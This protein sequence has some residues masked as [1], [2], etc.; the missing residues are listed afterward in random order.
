[1]KGAIIMKN[2]SDEKIRKALGSEPL[3]E[4]LSPDNIKKML[5]EKAPAKKRN[6]ITHTV[7]RITAAAAACAIICGF[8]VYFTE[9]RNSYYTDKT[10]GKNS[11]VSESSEAAVGTVTAQP[12]YMSGASDYNEIYRMLES[13]AENAADIYD[14][15]IFDDMADGA[16]PETAP[17]PGGAMTPTFTIGDIEENFN[18]TESS[19]GNESGYSE[20]YNQE[21]GVLEGD[22]AL[23]DGHYIYYMPAWTDKNERLYLN[24]A[25]AD[26]GKFV[27]GSRVEIMLPEDAYIYS[28]INMFLYNE[29]IIISGCTYTYSEAQTEMYFCGF[30]NSS[31]CSFVS[32]YTTGSE[33]ELIGN[34][35]QE[36]SFSDVRIAPDGYLY[37]I[38]NYISNDF[39]NIENAEDYSAYIPAYSSNDCVKLIPPENILLPGSYSSDSSHMQYTVIGSLDL[40][41]KRKF[42]EV[43]NKA[44]A[45]YTGG[46]YCSQD[47][48]YTVCGYSYS[49]ITRIALD[50]GMITPAASGKVDG[51]I[52][53]Q[54]SMSEYNGYFRVAAT[55]E[56]WEDS[57]YSMDGES[58]AVVSHSLSHIDNRVYV[59]DLD[60]NIIGSIDGLGID[61]TIKS[62]SFSGN[63]AYIVTY[64]Q[65]DP[66]YSI[67]LSNPARPVLMDEYKILGYSTYMQQWSDGL[68]LGF[69]KNAD[70]NGIEDGIKLVMFDNS[71]PYNLDEKGLYIMDSSHFGVDFYESYIGSAAVNERKALLIAPEKNLI[72]V[73]VNCEKYSDSDYTVEY[74]YIFFSYEDGKFVNKGTISSSWSKSG[75][76]SIY[77]RAIYIG[78][79]VYVLS[80]DSFTGAD[81]ATIT[82]TDTIE[83]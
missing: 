43:D 15:T 26:D 33:P 29:M 50:N 71:D 61:E 17:E 34:Y 68:L 67:D 37:L 8:G 13:S 45:G 10:I 51:Y 19:D 38:T 1:M 24:V 47:N 57:Y 11:S 31:S 48:L 28:D 83:F 73:P 16:V 27:S 80:A 55:V 3:P 7:A 69:G 82:E 58:S 77:D 64:R 35:F 9:Q 46:I 66:L 18:S 70:E 78:D 25:E 42:T 30:E 6:K 63:T 62:A 22:I 14:Y 23:T 79:Y 12:S 44:L 53:D 59:L 52:K 49:E 56:V 60:L 74:S 54:F 2:S 21:E 36:G 20:T 76:G 39:S 75:G 81:I 5:D 4:Q 41:T 72:G 40:N 32:V 65:T